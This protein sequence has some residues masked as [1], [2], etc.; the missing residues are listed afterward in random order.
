MTYRRVRCDECWTTLMYGG[1]AV[2]FDGVFLDHLEH[3]RFFTERNEDLSQ[4]LLG[5]YYWTGEIDA[6]YNCTQCLYEKDKLVHN[7][8]R[9]QIRRDYRILRPGYNDP[10]DPY[11]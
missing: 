3:V 1:N 9:K 11:D 7:R 4:P 8:S 2:P 6:T 5:K 10:Y